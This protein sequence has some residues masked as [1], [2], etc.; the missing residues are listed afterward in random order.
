[1]GMTYREALDW[2]YGVQSRGIKLGLETMHRLCGALDIELSRADGRRVIHVAGTNGKGSVCAMATAIC[3]AANKRAGL[4]TSPHLV[5]FRERIRLGQSMIPEEYIVEGVQ[6]VRE[7]IEGWEEPPTFFE[8]TTA[9]AFGWFQRQDVEWIV[10]ETGLGGRLDA[11]NVMTPTVSVFTKIDVD[12][13]DYLGETVAEIAREKAGIIK[14]GVPVVTVP[15]APEVEEVL[16]LAAQ[17]MGA[18]FHV[19]QNPV[20]T[21]WEISL[22]G[23]YQRWNAALAFAAVVA[24]GLRPELSVIANG[25]RSVVWPG[26]FQLALDERVV[27]DG[28]HNPAAAE[29]LAT[30]WRERFGDERCTLITG[31]LGDKDVSGILRPLLPMAARVLCVPVRNPRSMPERELA[32]LVGTLASQVPCDIRPDFA[33]AFEHASSHS[34]RVLVAGSLFLV[35]E[36]LAHLGLM[37]GEHEPSAQ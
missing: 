37:E 1:M 35:G 3:C 30:T 6:Q 7:V 13:A 32:R 31:L 19:I 23:S 16:R 36:A 10:L 29:L 27:L 12:H 34:S 8:I 33:S 28:A 15:Q 22:T 25:L 14:A 9:L 5:S 18:P 24:S 20:G 17:E 2:L 11:T 26:R 21:G 4:Y